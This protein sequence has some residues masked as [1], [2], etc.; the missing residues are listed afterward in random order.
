MYG[1]ANGLDGSP[2][3][4]SLL[5]FEPVSTLGMVKPSL[6]FA[7]YFF[8][9]HDDE[10]SVQIREGGRLKVVDIQPYNDGAWQ[11]K[12]VTLSSTP[13]INTV[14]TFR[15]RRGHNDTVTSAWAIDDVSIV[16]GDCVGEFVYTVERV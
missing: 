7:V 10:L 9:N 13:S 2:D 8:G 1:Y 4:E 5:I 16:D 11:K 12:C 14:V 6:H 15:A 3:N